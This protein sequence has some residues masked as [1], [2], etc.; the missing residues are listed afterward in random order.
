MLD[1]NGA[2]LQSSEIN[3]LTFVIPN[4]TQ[5]SKKKRQFQRGL[6]I[7]C[8]RDVSIKKIS[9]IYIQMKR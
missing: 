4:S 2:I 3:D 1:D 5:L 7:V 9:S 6:N 8:L